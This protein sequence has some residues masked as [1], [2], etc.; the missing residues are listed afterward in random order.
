MLAVTLNTVG[1]VPVALI[2]YRASSFFDPWMVPVIYLVVQGADASVALIAGY[3]YDCF[4]V[5]FLVFPF[6]LAVV[7]SILTVVGNSSSAI[8]AAAV[9]F[10]LVLGMQES[11]YRAA[12]AD[13]T[14]MASRGKAYGMFNT[15]YGVGFLLGGAIFGF[16]IGF[17]GYEFAAVLYTLTIQFLALILLKLIRR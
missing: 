12:V 5:K 2:L 4:G 8:V 3:V 11:V 10:G 9:V 6:L 17:K 13:L 16:F 1:L 14:P 7:P 15:V